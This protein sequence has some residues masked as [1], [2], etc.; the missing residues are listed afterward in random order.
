[1]ALE[2]AAIGWLV[3]GGWRRVEEVAE[4]APALEAGDFMNA[5]ELHN[6]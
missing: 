3:E 4:V 1:M 6:A 5:L 2:V